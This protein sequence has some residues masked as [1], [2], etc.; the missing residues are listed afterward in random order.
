M[1]QPTHGAVGHGNAFVSN[2]VGGV[3]SGSEHGGASPAPRS[4]AAAAA[5]A[6]QYR[7]PKINLGLSAADEAL[8]KQKLQTLTADTAN[9]SSFSPRAKKQSAAARS[10]YV[11]RSGSE[12][13]GS[14]DDTKRRSKFFKHTEKERDQER[15]R[16]RDERR[17]VK[18]D[19]E[20][21]E[22]DAAE[23]VEDR[24]RKHGEDGEDENGW[25]KKRRRV[26][27]A[28]SPPPDLDNF[29]PKKVSRR[30]ERKLVQKVQKI[31]PE[32]LMESANYQRFNR[33][34]ETIFDQ[35]EEVRARID[36]V[37]FGVDLYLCCW[38]GF[39]GE[40]FGKQG[41]V[42]FETI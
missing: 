19:D 30:L 35:V 23:G 11:E 10:K 17:R 32:T 36:S 38:T 14:E 24:K 7:L 39:L 6:Q 12:S 27:E 25:L 16:R 21:F 1:F 28:G 9:Y 3:S 29:V 13:E 40:K 2:G 37:V 33:I 22:P 26:E 8:M 42:T 4:R 31:D 41:E 15:R 34:L 20:D 5:P 18:D